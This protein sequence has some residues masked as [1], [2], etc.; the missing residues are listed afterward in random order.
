[1]SNLTA[2]QRISNSYTNGLFEIQKREKVGAQPNLPYTDI[3]FIIT[4]NIIYFCVTA[5]LYFFMQKKEK[6]FNV[7]LKPIIFYYNLLCVTLAGIVVVGIVGYWLKYGFHSF[8]CNKENRGVQ[9]HE[10]AVVYWIFYIQKYVE[11]A[12]TWFFLLR[13]SFRQVSFLHIFHHSSITFV[14]GLIIP[15][16]FSGDMYLPILLNAIVHCVMYGYYAATSLGYKFW[17]KKYLTMMQ[18]IQFC[19]ISGQSFYAW[20]KGPRC[21][22]P[23]FAKAL[24]ICY[25]FSMLYL[26]GQF[27]VGSY[28]NKKTIQ[29]EKKN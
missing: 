24:L 18:L 10:L 23:D 28:L 6:G 21:G 25:M 17:W 8:V 4:A 1:M 2:F 20:F 12:D 3:E 5:F 13:K 9:G 29:K 11:F 16:A 7:L 26:F 19:L 22:T 15:H 14:V 27:F